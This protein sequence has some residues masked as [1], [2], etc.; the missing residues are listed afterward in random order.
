[1]KILI[2]CYSR[3][4]ITK[5]VAETLQKKLDCDIEEITD[6]D[7]YKGI[8]GWLKGGFNAASNR[9]SE[10]DEV[11][12]SPIKYDLTIIGSPVWASRLATPVS[13]YINKYR[14]EFTKVAGF[15]TCNSGGY[16][17]AFKDMEIKT[18]KTLKTKMVLTKSDFE[19]DYNKKIDK[20]VESILK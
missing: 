8:I 3:S 19:Q 16:E 11:K 4:G 12:Y 20:F 5:E 18:K 7:H 2:V 10:I 9:Y 6:N 1:M 14:N 13:T 17:E 15:L